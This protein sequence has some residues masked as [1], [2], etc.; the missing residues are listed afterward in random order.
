[1]DKFTYLMNYVNQTQGFDKGNVFFKV[2][3][4]AFT[5]LEVLQNLERRYRTH[6]KHVL[7]FTVL[8]QQT[9]KPFFICFT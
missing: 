9:N 5:N 8:Y 1:M 7:S 6:S 3:S 2:N 4:Y